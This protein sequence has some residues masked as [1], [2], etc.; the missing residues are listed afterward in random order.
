[1]V[2][3]LTTSAN[4]QT[5]VLRRPAL[6]WVRAP[7]A[8]RCIDPRKLAEHVE[9]L[10]GPVL[11]R[12]SEAEHTVEGQVD[13]VGPDTLRVRVRVLDI[14]DHVLGERQF[15]QTAEDCKVLTPAIVFVIGMA[16]DPEV[17]AHGLPPALVALLGQSGAPPEQ[18]LL[19][20]LEREP[21]APPDPTLPRAPPPEPVEPPHE[22]AVQLSAFG[23]ASTHELPG[24]AIAFEVRGL[25]TIV[26]RYAVGGYVRGGLQAGAYEIPGQHELRTSMYDLGLLGCEGSDPMHRFRIHGCIGT[27]LSVV[28]GRG[29]GFSGGNDGGASVAFGVV[30]QLTPRVRITQHWGL[31]LLAYFRITTTERG[32][33]IHTGGNTGPTRLAHLG[34]LSGGVAIGPTLEF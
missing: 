21:P 28:T 3:A 29:G 31:G 19:N 33:T 5:I 7:E 25:Y 2:L 8:M 6:H 32:F 14:D 9:A 22:P 17:A 16:I 1:V 34:L 24:P 15:E 27:E 10:T 11:V 18:A 13:A 26:R 4:A 30:A 23:G 20:E 12:P